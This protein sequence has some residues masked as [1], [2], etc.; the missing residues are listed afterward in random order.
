MPF[1]TLHQIIRIND[2]ARDLTEH[3]RVGLHLAVEI[4][5]EAGEVVQR[6]S[7]IFEQRG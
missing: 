3:I 1:K 4:A 6:T 5:G 2:R 7:E